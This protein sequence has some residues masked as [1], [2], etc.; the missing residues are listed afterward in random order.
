MIR[1]EAISMLQQPLQVGALCLRNRI[2]LAPLAGVSDVPFRRICAEHHAGL[3]FVEMMAANAVQAKN[4]RTLQMLTRHPDEPALGVQLSGPTV[5]TVLRATRF[6]AQRDFDIIDINMGCP[7]KKIVQK[8]WGSAL[9]KEPDKILKMVQACREVVK[10][11]LSVK[12]RIGFSRDSVNVRETSS[13]IAEGG[14]D[15]ITIHGRTRED[16]YGAPVQFEEIASGFE[17]ARRIHPG[18]VCVGNGNILQPE[19]AVDMV[20]KTGCDAVMVSRGALGD[21]WIFSELAGKGSRHVSP[22]DW[23][24]TV[25]RHIDYHEEFHGAIPFAPMLFRKHLLWYV[26]GFRHARRHRDELANS[27]SFEAMRGTLKNF[28]DSQREGELRFSES[29]PKDD[30]AEFDPKYDMH[31]KL[32]RSAADQA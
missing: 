12:I 21:P 3:T 10:G 7:V 28:A 1:H 2:L 5:E 11:P 20:Q 32:D 31:R 16:N 13:A 19:G 22:E 27:D 29:L 8:G 24:T 9:L 17:A 23:L 14:A 25:L 26:T 18:I 6:L 30:A 4:R 15:L